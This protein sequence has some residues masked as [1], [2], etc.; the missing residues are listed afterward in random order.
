M[1]TSDKQVSLPYTYYQFKSFGLNVQAEGL[2]GVAPA[3]M[4]VDA[5]AASLL[6]RSVAAKGMLLAVSIPFHV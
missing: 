6:P 1:E 5:Q 2:L 3:G 4:V